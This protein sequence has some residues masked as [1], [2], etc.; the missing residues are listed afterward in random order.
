[1]HAFTQ[2]YQGWSALML[3][4]ANHAFTVAEHWLLAHL[5]I[6]QCGLLDIYCSMASFV[7]AVDESRSL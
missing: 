5:L 7:S 6:P 2:A 1:M 4:T 3:C